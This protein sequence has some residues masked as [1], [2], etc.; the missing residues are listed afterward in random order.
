MLLIAV[1]ADCTGL[2]QPVAATVRSM[3]T[4]SSRGVSFFPL[5]KHHK[6][7]NNNAGPPTPDVTTFHYLNRLPTV[8]A[9]AVTAGTVF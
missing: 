6:H 5:N 1:D 2:L 4:V 3:N 7:H 9:A 8:V